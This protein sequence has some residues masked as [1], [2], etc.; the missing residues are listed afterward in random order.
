MDQEGL[1]SEYDR[2]F[3]DDDLRKSHRQQ[4]NAIALSSWKVRIFTG[5]FATSVLSNVFMLIK[6][7]AYNDRSRYGMAFV[8]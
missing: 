7:L 4:P 8:Q 1:L 3:E 6:P 2:K 5:L